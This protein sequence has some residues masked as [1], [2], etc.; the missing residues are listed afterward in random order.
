MLAQVDAGMDL[1]E[2]AIFGFVLAGGV[3]TLIAL[4]ITVYAM[5]MTRKVEGHFQEI[6]QRAS[7]TEISAQLVHELRNPLSALRANVKALLVSP[8]QTRVIADELDSDIVELNA[9]LSAFLKL[10]R[11][12]DEHSEAM[13][14][15]E[16]LA[17]AV[18][19][20]EPVLSAQGI[21]VE[22]HIPAGL[23]L[24]KLR[25]ASM[26]DALLNI[27]I[28]AGQSGQ[29]GG[30]IRLSVQLQGNSMLIVTEDS[31]EG[32]AP[33]HM[34]HL[35]EAFYTT[36]ADGNG[37]GL[38]IVQRVAA[39]HQGQVL[40]ENRQEGGARVVLSVPLQAKETPGWWNKLKKSFPV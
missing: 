21:R 28:N 3:S 6:Y 17:D 15:G 11:Q 37:L 24:V 14:I 2:R 19:L 25:R 22:T 36:R 16:L 27:L 30:V 13:A 1:I 40:V 7:L 38:A 23:P 34:P 32:I 12:H 10:T 33:E 9:K 18:R 29:R 8:E 39:A 4:A 31:G 20:A 5:A 35:F 26:R